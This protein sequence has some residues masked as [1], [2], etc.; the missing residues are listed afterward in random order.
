[1]AAIRKEFKA[2]LNIKEG[3][4]DSLTGKDPRL[5]FIPAP[6]DL[7]HLRGKQLFRGSQSLT[8]MPSYDLRN[9]DKL[10]PVKDQGNA[11]T[12]WAFASYGSLESNLMPGQEWNFS[13]NNMKNLLSEECPQGYDRLPDEGGNQFMSTAYLV[14]WSGPVS[15]EVDPYDPNSNGCEEYD[16]LKHVQQIIFIPDRTGSLDNM[17]IKQAIMNYGAVFTGMFY[18]DENYNPDNFS[19]YYKGTAYSNHAVCLVGWDDNF[20]R[21][22]FAT[23]SPADGAFIVRNSWGKDWGEGG[24]FYVSY[25]DSRIGKDNALFNN[26]ESTENYDAIYQYDPL[27]WVAS[28]GYSSAT[29]WFA[30]VFTA[31]AGE[32]L[33]AVS[34]YTGAANS[35]YQ[36]MVYLNPTVSSPT[37]GNQVKQLSGKISAPGYYT[38]SF[39]KPVPLTAGQRF[40]LVVKLTT[41]GYEY[42]IPVEMPIS[43]YSSN[44][45]SELGQSFISRNGRSWKD[46]NTVWENTNVCIKGFINR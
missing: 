19:Y 37:S 42:P 28:I 5:G 8:I 16:V 20:D 41:P 40:S 26:A 38:R 35:D 34:W 32:E 1:M 11:G 30:N 9:L 33:A 46:I 24:Y 4:S 15:A 39:K 14:R 44:A 2:Y 31:S 25:Y 27:G 43:G 36:L 13:E 6:L 12:C 29:G 23:A 17:N 18:D 21:K 22:K 7:S 45:S 3:T 10:T